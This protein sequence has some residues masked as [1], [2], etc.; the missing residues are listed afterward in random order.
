MTGKYMKQVPSR[1]EKLK[2][3]PTIAT[4]IDIL[5]IITATEVQNGCGGW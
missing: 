5:S 1:H 2:T 4:I 3:Y